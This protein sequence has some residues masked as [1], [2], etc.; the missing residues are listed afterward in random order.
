MAYV[1]NQ[2]QLTAHTAWHCC[3]PTPFALEL[4]LKAHIAWPAGQFN[5]QPTLQGRNALVDPGILSRCDRMASCLTQNKSVPTLHAVCRPT[6][7][8]SQPTLHGISARTLV[9]TELNRMASC[10]TQNNP[11]PTVHAVCCPTQLQLPPALHGI[12]AHTK[13]ITPTL[14]GILPDPEQ[15][16]AHVVWHILPNPNNS[17]HRALHLCPHPDQLTAFKSCLTQNNWSC[18][19]NPTLHDILCPTQS[20]SHATLHGISAPTQVTTQPSLHG[21]LTAPEQLKAHIA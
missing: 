19:S 6:Q 18:N 3:L 15:L 14:H 16:I 13:H 9:N 12:P 10:L 17:Q 1:P 21:I 7:F 5:S 4:Q 2:A 8:S 20:N 11:K